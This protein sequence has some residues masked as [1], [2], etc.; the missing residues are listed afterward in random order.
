MTGTSLAPPTTKMM[1]STSSK[2][3]RSTARPVASQRPVTARHAI[4]EPTSQGTRA[5]EPAG[6]AAPVATTPYDNYTFSPIRE[7]TVSRAMTKRYFSDMDT[8][9]EADVVIIGAGSAGLACAY[10]LAK[11]R[12]DA[13]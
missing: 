8:Y 5:P 1:L 6:G 9:A 11:L 3:M 7:A 10:E 4:M 2:M 13:K 12:P